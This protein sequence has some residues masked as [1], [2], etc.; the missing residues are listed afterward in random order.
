MIEISKRDIQYIKKIR[1]IRIFLMDVR[2]FEVPMELLSCS[3]G[4]A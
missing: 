1:E 4:A 2:G 3:T